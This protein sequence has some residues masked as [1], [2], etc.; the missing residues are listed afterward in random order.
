MYALLARYGGLSQI[1]GDLRYQVYPETVP[2]LGEL[3]LMT[4]TSCL[5]SFRPPNHLIL[6]ATRFSRVPAFIE[7]I[8]VEA[9]PNLT[10]PLK[11]R[12]AEILHT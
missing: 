3:P 12:I 6:M 10:D 2:G 4:I 9:L 1:L 5:P 8:D 7:L 11:T